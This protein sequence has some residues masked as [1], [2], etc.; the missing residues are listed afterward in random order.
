[1]EDQVTISKSALQNLISQLKASQ[2][3]NL[4]D[5]CQTMI[6]NINNNHNERA[7]SPTTESSDCNSLDS[8]DDDPLRCV[9]YGLCLKIC[10]LS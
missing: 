3:N 7:E 9:L 1:M 10:D 5:E 4:A 8:V 2:L 6:N